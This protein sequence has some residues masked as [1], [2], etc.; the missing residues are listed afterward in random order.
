MSLRRVAYEIKHIWDH[1]EGS[2]QPGRQDIVLVVSIA[3][4]HWYVQG[5]HL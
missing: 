4:K 1:F 5:W 3:A 2:N